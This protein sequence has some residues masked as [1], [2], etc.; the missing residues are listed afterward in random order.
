MEFYDGARRSGIKAWALLAVADKE[1]TWDVHAVSPAGAMGI[2]Q[3]MP[4]TAIAYARSEGL[5]ITSKEQIFEPV[6]NVR[7]GIR[8]LVDNYRGAVLTG[9]SPEGDTTRALWSYNG[10]GEAY[11]RQVMEKAAF[12]QKRLEA[13][14][15]GK[16][17]TPKND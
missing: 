10:G 17:P 7:N 14:L 9:K 2:M 6:F 13:P 3:L 16:I 4:G 1:S 5:P 15:Q 12:Y 8:V 11:A